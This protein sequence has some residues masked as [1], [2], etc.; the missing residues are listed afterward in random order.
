MAD[1]LENS[2]KFNN[3]PVLA[4]KRLSN[5]GSCVIPSM[6]ESSLTSL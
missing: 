2:A 5:L 4:A 6:F 3:E 1:D